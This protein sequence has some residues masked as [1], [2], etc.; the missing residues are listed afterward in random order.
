MGAIVGSE[1]TKNNVSSP[2]SC[3]SAACRDVVVPSIGE[4]IVVMGIVDIL[5]ITSPQTFVI[6]GTPHGQL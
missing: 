6:Y 5:R 2:E 4:G 1:G 3:S